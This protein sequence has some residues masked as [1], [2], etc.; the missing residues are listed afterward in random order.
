MDTDAV[1]AP[2]RAAQA[3][4]GPG[5]GVGT[6]G[7]EGCAARS[8][9]GGEAL[10]ATAGHTRGWLVVEWPGTWG[11]DP[12]RAPNADR[13]VAAVLADRTAELG[14]RLTLVR[15]HDRDPR[16]GRQVY[17]VWTGPGGPWAEETVLGGLEGLLEADLCALAQ[18][19]R[20]GF[21][22]PLH[23]PV[24]LVCTHG[25]KD[26][27]CA[28]FG[29]PTF[30]ALSTALQGGVWESTH[31]G[32]DRFAANLVCLPHGLYFGRVGPS[33]ALRIAN[34]YRE[35]RIEL[36]HYRGRPCFPAPIQ[37]AD[38]HVRRYEGLAGVEALRPERHRR[39]G[40]DR[41]EVVLRSADH[42]YHVQLVVEAA[43]ESRALVCGAPESARPRSWR[44][45]D[46]RRTGHRSGNADHIRAGD[47][48]DHVRGATR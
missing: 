2:D 13:E 14:L 43:D 42:R 22:R 47:P 41:H 25:R 29:R 8:A 1:E 48:D 40:P 15:R 3:R 17:L 28:R 44:L 46:L 33:E 34:A 24:F 26:P 32:G 12:L 20:P 30:Q 16:S 27:C 19:R 38:Y 10:F 11:R 9:W 37:A 45:T 6:G 23:D 31:V 35:G 4:H 36:D 39:V 7:Y 5:R 21:G 18:G